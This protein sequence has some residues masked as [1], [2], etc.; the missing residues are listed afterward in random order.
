M[1]KRVSRKGDGQKKGAEGEDGGSDKNSLYIKEMERARGH[2]ELCRLFGARHL[3]ELPPLCLVVG[4]L[5]EFLFSLFIFA[6][7]FRV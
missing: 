3:A 4:K 1:N 2:K 6:R 7:N 5:I